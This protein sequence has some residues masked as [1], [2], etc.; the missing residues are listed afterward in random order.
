MDVRNIN[1]LVLAYL[2]DSVYEIQI[3]NYLISKKIGNVNN[4]DK[5]AVNFVSAVNQAKILDKLLEKNILTEEELYTVNRARNYKPNSKPRYV[6]I[7]TYN[8]IFFNNL[9]YT[10]H[11]K[12]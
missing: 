1:V 11:R 4:M 5:E 10:F 2:G 3:R 7:K 12:F 6:D 9:K 8:S